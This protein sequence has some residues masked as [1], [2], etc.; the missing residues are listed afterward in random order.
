VR[1]KQ[2]SRLKH[3]CA[4]RRLMIGESAEGVSEPL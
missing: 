2:G 1:P 3:R 4:P